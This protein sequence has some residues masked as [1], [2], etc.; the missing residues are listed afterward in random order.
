MQPF[1]FL[2]ALWGGARGRMSTYFTRPFIRIVGWA[3]IYGASP[4]ISLLRTVL[5]DESLVDASVV[6]KA[7]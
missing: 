2:N 7:Q 6:M 1:A 5:E 4:V 3:I